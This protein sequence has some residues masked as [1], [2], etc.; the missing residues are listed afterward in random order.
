MKRSA[1]L[2]VLFC[3]FWGCS[4]S[5]KPISMANLEGRWKVLAL[6]NNGNSSEPLEGQPQ[7]IEIKA[8]LFSSFSGDTEIESFSKME[9][10]IELSSMP[11]KLDLTREYKGTSYTIPCIVQLKG[12]ELKICSPRLPIGDPTSLVRP[13]TFDTKSEQVTLITATRAR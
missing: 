1:L 8:G 6:E 5:T 12:D 4:S 2:L 7:R 13:K 11:A 9:M 10:K 3:L